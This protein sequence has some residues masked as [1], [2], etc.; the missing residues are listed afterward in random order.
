MAVL[1]RVCRFLLER[2]ERGF[3]IAFGQAC[4]P[5]SYLGALGWYFFW[6]VAGTGIYLYIFFD[7]GVTDA[8]ASVERITHDQ[9]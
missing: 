1:K 5:F 2:V 4:N 7:T 8:Y 9:W 3:D 6:I